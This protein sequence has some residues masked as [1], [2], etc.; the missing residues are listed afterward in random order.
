MSTNRISEMAK[1][2]SD[3]E[4]AKIK[5]DAL[6]SMNLVVSAVRCSYCGKLYKDTEEYDMGFETTNWAVC[7]KCFRKFCDAMLNKS[8]GGVAK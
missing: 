6:E 8:A 5:R 4:L 7:F 3:M 1:K 2:L